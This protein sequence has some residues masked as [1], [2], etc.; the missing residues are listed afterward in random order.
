MI[1]KFLWI[2]LVN[3]IKGTNYK[4]QRRK[5]CQLLSGWTFQTYEQLKPSF[6]WHSIYIK[7]KYASFDSVNACKKKKLVD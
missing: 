2:I 7:K 5:K 6:Y 4:K 3:G 1:L